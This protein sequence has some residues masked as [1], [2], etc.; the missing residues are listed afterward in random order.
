MPTPSLP[1][2]SSAKTIPANAD[3]VILAAHGEDTE[4]IASDASFLKAVAKKNGE[5]SAA[6]AR[7]GF[8]ASVNATS[9]LPGTGEQVIVLAGLGT[10]ADAEAT[11]EDARMAAGAGVRA[12][13]GLGKGLRVAVDFEAVEPEVLRAVTEGAILGSYTFAGVRSGEAESAPIAELIMVAPKTDKAVID[14]AT[15][16]ATAVLTAREWVNIPPNLLFPESFADE[17]KSHCKGS[18]VTVEVLDDKQ[19]QA[20]GFGGL[21]T[22][23]GGSTRKP[24]LARLTYAPRGA[25]AHLALVGKGITFDSGGLDIKPPASMITM[26]CDMGGAAAVI[27]A[28]RAIADLGLKVQVTAYAC[29]AEN[30]P[31][32]GAY[33][34]S[35]VLTIYGGTTV[36]N[37]NTD[38]EGRLVMADGLARANEDNAD[39]VVDIATLTGACMVAL[40]HDTFGVF[41][42]D[43]VV[44]AAVLDAAEAAGEAAWQLPIPPFVDDVLKSKVADMTSGGERLGGAS[45]AAGFL[46]RFVDTD[47]DWAHIDIAGPAFNEKGP[48]G[49]ISEGGT[50]VGV[51]TL[52]ELARS[53]QA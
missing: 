11:L 14:E 23:G 8:K 35:D 2:I 36:E 53:M 18:K 52:I 6:A 13:A 16:I 31:D 27:A 37:Y 39:L 38:A 28:T 19:L 10:D 1:K 24:R 45:V 5:L 40:G 7:L 4:I 47:T 15:A 34:P 49:H 30:M 22:V 26:K 9:L 50:G 20:Q 3:V 51:R 44:A 17:A 33:R 41:S 32:G 21:M 48:K 43:D 42:D 29:L 25:K 46:R 12:A